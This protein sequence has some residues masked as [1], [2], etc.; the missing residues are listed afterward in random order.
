[1]RKR[2]RKR[3][4]ESY[5]NKRQRGVKEKEAKERGG[6]RRGVDVYLIE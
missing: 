3:K 5:I 6:G 4:R 2:R 1:M